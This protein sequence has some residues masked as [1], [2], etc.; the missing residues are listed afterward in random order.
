MPCILDG[1]SPN[2][3]PRS[4]FRPNALQY[5]PK[6]QFLLRGSQIS[7]HP[8][9]RP[10]PSGGLSDRLDPIT[11]KG[12]KKSEPKRQFLCRF[13]A[14]ATRPTREGPATH[15]ISE[16]FRRSN[17]DSRHSAQFLVTLTLPITI[18]P[19]RLLRVYPQALARGEEGP[20]PYRKGRRD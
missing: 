16:N 9:G 10:R 18:K 12:Q 17:K 1:F 5:N 3:Q 14:V 15:C 2:L 8:A 4:V 19:R 11:R 13:G 6:G 7:E 20:R